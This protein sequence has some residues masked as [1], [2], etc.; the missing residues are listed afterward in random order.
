M[1]PDSSGSHHFSISRRS[2]SVIS[3]TGLWYLLAVSDDMLAASSLW[4]GT[5]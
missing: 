5:Y 4:V 1:W 3:V 2:A